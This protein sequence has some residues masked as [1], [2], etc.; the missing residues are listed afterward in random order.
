MESDNPLAHKIAGAYKSIFAQLTRFFQK[1]TGNQ[2]DANDLSQDV[3]TLWLNRKSQTPVQDQRAFLFKIANNVLIEHWRKNQRQ[4]DIY[5]D[6]YAAEEA[7]QPY[8]DHQEPSHVLEHQQRLQL[9]SEALDGLP[10]RRKE[11][12]VLYCFDG[13]LQSEIAERMEISVSMVE[14][15]IAAALVHCK[16]YVDAAQENSAH[17]E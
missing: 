15:H 1:R 3:F 12:F 17:D 10:P 7:S 2:H 13:L 5:Q 16:R 4:Q 14:K 6:N 8:T 11:A 9:F